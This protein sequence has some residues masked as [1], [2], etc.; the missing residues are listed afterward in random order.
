MNKIEINGKTFIFPEK[1]DEINRKQYIRLSKIL[2]SPINRI[3]KLYRIL[4]IWI[5]KKYLA[6]I[7]GDEL[8]ILLEKLAFIEDPT[9]IENH[10]ETIS[11]PKNIFFRQ[12]LYGTTERMQEITLEEFSYADFYFYML[13]TTQDMQYIDK[14]ISILYKPK[15][16]RKAN[17]FDTKEAEKIEK[18]LIYIYVWK[19][20]AILHYFFSCKRSITERFT[21]IFQKAEPKEQ[22]TPQPPD[23]T[24]TIISLA[25]DYITA[26]DDIKKTELITALLFIEQ[27]KKEADEIKEK[28]NK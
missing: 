26:L 18:K 10:F 3:V 20:Q 6:K 22:K 21:S 19:R 2:F 16:H 14:I 25:G 11:I 17:I 4:R 28:Y 12:K 15:K 9:H 8:I 24:S 27:K 23:W 1:M 5:P 13:N 7:Q